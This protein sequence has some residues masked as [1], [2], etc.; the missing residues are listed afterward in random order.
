MASSMSLAW[1]Q[2]EF[3]QA[4][5][6]NELRTRRLVQMAAAAMERPAGTVTR[7]MRNAAE[8]EGAF[9]FIE[10]DNVRAC[11]IALSN[12]EATIRRCVQDW[13]YVAV[14]QTT[15]SIIDHCGTKGFGPVSNRNCH[16]K[17]RGGEVMS[18]LAVSQRGVT[19]GLVAQC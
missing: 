2:G 9:R 12:H 6:G 5:L 11:D 15:L 8:R 4:D 19:I 13:V 14:D 10:N 1:A 7:V 17:V 3:G 18:A 16:H